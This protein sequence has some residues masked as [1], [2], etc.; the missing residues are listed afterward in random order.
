MEIL[1]FHFH[2]NTPPEKIKPMLLSY[3]DITY[4]IE[5]E[6]SYY[7][8]DKPIVL[9]AGEAIVFPAGVMR[10]RDAGEKN[11]TFAS[12]NACFEDELS[13]YGV[14]KNAV[15]ADC[16]Y[17]LKQLNEC[18]NTAS[19]KRE[20]KCDALLSYLLAKLTESTDD[21]TNTYITTVKQM[22]LENPNA[23]YTLSEIAERV[24]LAPPYLCALFK[25]HE[26]INLFDY[27]GRKRTNYAKTLIVSYDLPLYAVAERAGFSDYYAF[28]HA[29]KKYEGVSAAQFK[30][31]ARPSHKLNTK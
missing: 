3:T 29:F 31:N 24:H 10:E 15:D 8:N 27:I 7:F 22:I 17:I 12:I 21:N 9:H 30:K 25:K 13:L 28:S 16:V 5:G 1:R 2:K 26:G 11:A 4:L 14:I 19:A 20:D 6:L 23:R 18:Y